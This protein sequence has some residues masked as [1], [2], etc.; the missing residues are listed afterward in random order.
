MIPRVE[1][2]RASRW[3]SMLSVLPGVGVALLP[4]GTCPAC[5]PAYAG[6]LGASLWN[7]WRP[8]QVRPA[9]ACA[10]CAPRNLGTDNRAHTEGGSS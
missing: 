8:R 9:G 7:A 3:P 1:R 6:L 4:I 2:D 5:W 10:A